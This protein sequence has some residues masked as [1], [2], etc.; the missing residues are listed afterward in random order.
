[1]AEVLLISDPVRQLVMPHA[2]ASEL[3]K[4]ALDEGMESMY[5]DGLRKAVLG[6]TTVEEVIRVAEEA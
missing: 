1:M 6:L 4:G 5:Q 2:N 3:L